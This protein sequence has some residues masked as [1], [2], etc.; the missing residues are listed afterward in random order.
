MAHRLPKTMNDTFREK[1]PALSRYVSK[2][3]LDL[4]HR[5]LAMVTAEMS[6][7]DKREL[8]AEMVRFGH[9]NLRRQG[10]RVDYL[11][12]GEILGAIP[13][14]LAEDQFAN[15]NKHFIY[16]LNYEAFGSKT[17]YFHPSLTSLLAD[18]ELNVNCED[19]T[20]PFPSCMFVYD[21]Q[22]AR[23]AMFA[24]SDKA[25]PT[26]GTI[27]V[28]ISRFPR[29][30]ADPGLILFAVLQHQDRFPLA[31]QRE[32]RM[33]FGTTLEDALRTEWTPVTDGP[34]LS[35]TTE[36]DEQFFGPGMRFIRMVVNSALYLTSADPD[37]SELL[38]PKRPQDLRHL[39]KRQR[40]NMEQS[41]RSRSAASYI[42]VG[43]NVERV[44]DPDPEADGG[45][46]LQIRIKVRSHWKTQHHGPANSLTK[47]IQ[48]MPYWR[49]PDAAEVIH[50]PFVV[51]GRPAEAEAPNEPIDSPPSP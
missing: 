49:G 14:Q 47:R 50:R 13:P 36:D 27:S 19:F 4:S 42:D 25:A 2:R 24:T 33:S 51:R 8:M 16:N 39:P 23:D 7:T 44:D 40:I 34:V 10:Y 22:E 32:L 5:D 43:R 12:D 9:Y 35:N 3:A 37:V 41:I 11:S 29:E 20:L 18:T 26:S 48:V 17:Y 28:F 45:R 15:I 30:N 1:F 38:H 46:S 21:S 31:I 6:E